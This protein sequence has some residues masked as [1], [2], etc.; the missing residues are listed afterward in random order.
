MCSQQES[1][2]KVASGNS[3]FFLIL[4]LLQEI[5]YII[6][7]CAGNFQISVSLTAA[8]SREEA[9]ENTCIVRDAQLPY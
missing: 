8:K 9:A 7:I 6:P 5:F 2:L 1:H 4:F 3:A